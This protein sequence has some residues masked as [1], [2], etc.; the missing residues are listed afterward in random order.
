MTTLRNNGNFATINKNSY[1][2]FTVTFGYENEGRK[3][4]AY[5]QTTV[6]NR[7]TYKSEKLATKKANEYLSL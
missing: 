3:N 6:T 5:G 2:E 1:G 7:K 4:D